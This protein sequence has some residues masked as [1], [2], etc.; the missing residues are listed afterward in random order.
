MGDARGE[1]SERGQL[2]GLDQPVLRG[3]Q[4]FQ[5]LCQ[6]KRAGFDAFEQSDVLDGNRGLVGKSRRQFY[7]LVGKRPHL[8]ARHD[9]DTDR[10]AFAQHRH[11]D[12]G[13]KIPQ[14][15]CLVEGV[16]GVCLD[17]G[18]MNDNSL[19]QR[20]CRCRTAIRHHRNVSDVIHELVGKSVEFT[21][22]KYAVLLPRDG[23]LL[24]IT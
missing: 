4:I 9:D 18:N 6:F 21:A 5:R 12:D 19:E 7:L 2:F 10:L 15:L 3:L 14:S 22:K 20:A 23:G 13:A 17:I 8:G 16:V 24:G 1:L 11:A